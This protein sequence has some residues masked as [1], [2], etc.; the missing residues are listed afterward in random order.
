MEEE[1][2]PYHVV[3]AVEH[4]YGEAHEK[5]FEEAAN[6]LNDPFPEDHDARVSWANARHHAFRVGSSSL[7]TPERSIRDVYL[8]LAKHGMLG[9]EYSM[10]A[11][12]A[13]R[14]SMA[15][16]ARAHG[17]PIIPDNVFAGLEYC[18]S[19]IIAV[20]TYEEM[21]MHGHYPTA[22]EDLERFHQLGQLIASV[23]AKKAKQL[24]RD[25]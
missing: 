11:T 15:M 21:M 13:S 5:A 17:V 25:A 9:T 4:L 24:L 8:G 12:C 7:M 18:C 16:I 19:N 22:P 14:L 2:A 23:A 6:A 1:D 10:I 3:W 20:R